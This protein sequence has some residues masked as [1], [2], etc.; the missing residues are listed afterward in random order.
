MAKGFLPTSSTSSPVFLELRDS[1]FHTINGMNSE[2]IVTYP[3]L[4]AALGIPFA[5]AA[6]WRVRGIK[7]AALMPGALMLIATA[8]HGSHYFVDVIAGVAATN[9]S[10]AQA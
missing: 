4:H 1:T 2:G 10:I 5:A 6:L 9:A 3:S 7:S 8:A